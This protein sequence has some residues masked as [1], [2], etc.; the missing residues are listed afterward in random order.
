MQNLTLDIRYGFRSL[1]RDK[2]FAATVLATL[3]ICIAANTATFAIVNSVVFR[4]LPVPNSSEIVIMSNRY[5]KAG[6]SSFN[7]S[8]VGD[9]YDRLTAVT[10][11]GQQALYQPTGQTIEIA[12]TPEQVQGMAVTPSFF[13]VVG[14]NPSRGRAF[15]TEESEIGAEQKIILSDSLWRTLY[16]SNPS[17]VGRDLRMGGKPFTIVGIM[18][19]GFNFVDPEVRFWIPLAITAEMKTIRHSNNWAH[20]GRLKPGATIQQVQSQIDALNAAN[21]DRFPSFREILINAGF[22]SVAESLQHVMIR[23]VEP[24]L[25]LL[26]G[27]A[28]LV[29]LIG[30]FNLINVALARLALRR[31]EIATRLALGGGRMQL[32]RQLVTENLIISLVAGVSG[33]LLG[34]AMLRALTLVHF[35]QFPRAS[36]VRIDATVAIAALAVAALIGILIGALQM[37]TVLR[38]NVSGVLHDSS[39]TGTSGT[40]ARRLR[41]ALVA[42]QVGFAFV[43]L[44]GAGLLLTSFRNLLAVNPG[45]SGER[46]LTASLTLPRARYADD[47]ARRALLNR[48]ITS[49]RN[50]PAVTAAGATTSIPLGGNYSDGA[51]LAESYS[52]RP[53]ESLI[54]PHQFSVTNGYFEAMKIPLVHGRYFTRA[55]T[56]TSLPVVVVDE[57]LAH[58]F[59]PNR[60]PIGQRMR[61]P[62]DASDL[63][64]IGPDTRWLTVVGVVRPVRLEDLSGSGNRAGAYYFPFA[65]SPSRAFTLAIRTAMESGSAQRAVRAQVAAID[66]DL[67]LFDVRTMTERIGLSLSSRRASMFL[68]LAFGAIAL[69]LSVIGIYGVL[70]HLVAQRRREIGIRVAL[71]STSAGIVR[72]VFREGAG[73][74]AVGIILGIA[75][76][77]AVRKIIA[78]QVYG[79]QPLDPVVMGSVVLLFAIVGLTACI[80][81]ARRALN[82]DPAA[83]LSE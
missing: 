74:V 55:D 11:L 4:P 8:A 26:W 22:H 31:K 76:A 68:A 60:D 81:P 78:D 20:I 45:F 65:Q 80:L 39:R 13:P 79:V 37:A 29:L 50:L 30:A 15:I 1:V 77:V 41:Q 18:P 61:Q 64:K 70:A 28:A 63:M 69:F 9:Y 71:G 33:V 23:D 12:G 17:V 49:I 44:A 40:R 19:A 51:V 82:V 32:L 16:G 3:A 25:F 67:A 52:M 2:A 48:A 47:A 24:M 46:V 75:G 6:V 83:V 57:N 21:L 5:P 10:A 43:L 27:G 14:I 73:L 58:H 42:S 59:W 72:L 62:N 38:M 53:G 56:E 34:V 35:D 54:S 36:E 7:Y 66:P